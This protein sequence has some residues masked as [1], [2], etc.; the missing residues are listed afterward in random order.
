VL[1]RPLRANLA[2]VRAAV[3]DIDGNLR[4]YRTARNFNP[5]MAMAADVTI[6][7]VDK[8]VHAGGIDPDDVHLPGLFVKRLVEQ[9]AHRD[10]IEHRTVRTLVGRS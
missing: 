2:I 8:L 1:E 5:I 9:S 6:A 4:F 3:G 10:V 7:E